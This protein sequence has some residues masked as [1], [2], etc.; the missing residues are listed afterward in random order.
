MAIPGLENK[1]SEAVRGAVSS[2][3]WPRRMARSRPSQPFR[4]F[5]LPQQTPGSALHTQRAGVANRR[6]ITAN[7]AMSSRRNRLIPL[8]PSPSPPLRPCRCPQVIPMLPDTDIGPL[9][10]RPTGVFLVRIIKAKDLPSVDIGFGNSIDGYFK[11]VQSPPALAPSLSVHMT[12][13]RKRPSAPVL[14]RNP[15][16][17]YSYPTARTALAVAFAGLCGPV[18]PA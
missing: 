7:H 17:S 15:S 18:L 2:F 16:V 6:F 10:A 13:K 12:R 3:V 11:V 4:R 1:I 9:Q 5:C 14:R 8:P